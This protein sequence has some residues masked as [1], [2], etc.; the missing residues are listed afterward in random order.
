LIRTVK[1]LPLF[2]KLVKPFYTRNNGKEIKRL[3][4]E[5]TDISLKEKALALFSPYI[6]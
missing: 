2:V 6:S 5:T 1:L 4:F 3:F